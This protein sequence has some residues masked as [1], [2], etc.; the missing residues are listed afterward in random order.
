MKLT[1]LI[2]VSILKIGMLTVNPKLNEPVKSA[3]SISLDN[4]PIKI[5]K[6]TITLNTGIHMKYLDA[7]NKNGRTILFIHGYTDTSRSFE[8]LIVELLKV[9]SDLRFIAIDLRGHGESS[10]PSPSS[11]NNFRIVDFTEDILDFMKLK[12]LT[13]VDL[14][15]HSMGSVIA[16]EIALEHPNKIS[17]LTMI[18]ALVNGKKNTAIQNFLIPELMDNWKQKLITKYGKDWKNKSYLL[19]PENLGPSVTNFLK[20]NWVTEAGV[21]TSVLETIY[22]ETIKIPLATWFGAL[23]TLSEFDHSKRMKKLKTPTLIIWGEGDEL[24]V[25]EDQERLLKACEKARQQN[26]TLVY[27][28]SYGSIGS[29]NKAPGHNL[30]WGNAK[31]VA[32][33]FLE[34]ISAEH[35][36]KSAAN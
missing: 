34:F 32:T 2:T 22:K 8:Q 24:T 1:L 20:E 4:E 3:L 30:H 28:R 35:P 33:D 14:V 5:T 19:S 17:S 26:G 10:M 31:I 12:N 13:K 23:E 25:K 18:G 6:K 16:Q 36:F 9:N 27:Y 11:S 7:G 15:G 29:Q 21:E